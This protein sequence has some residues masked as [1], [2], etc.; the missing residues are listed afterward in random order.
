MIKLKNYTT[1][2]ELLTNELLVTYINNFWND[3]FTD[4]KN[5][6]H[7][8]LMCKVQFTKEEMGYRTLGHLRK[9][10]FKDKELFIDYLTQRLSILNDSYVAL[11]ISNIS[12]SYIIK[13]GLSTDSNRAL[14]Q[15]LTDSLTFTHNFNNMKLPISMNPSD[16]GEIVVDNYVQSGGENL[17]RFIVN[18]GSRTY[19]IDISSDSLINK[20]RILGKI[21]LEWID[22]KIN[23]IES[24]VFK[25]EIKNST[26]YFMDSQVILRKQMLPAKAFKKTSVDNKLNNYFYTLDIETIKNNGKLIPY[27]ICAYN[28]FDYITSYGKDQQELFKTFFDQLLSKIQTRTTTYIYAH[29]LAGF[30]GI[31]LMKYLLE[32]GKVEPLLHNGKLI[33]IKLKIKIMSTENSKSE[34]KTIIFK[35]SFLLLPL[36]LRKLCLAFNIETSKGY[37]PFLLNNIYYSGVIPKFENWTGISLTQFEKIVSDYKGK[38]WS[39]QLEAIKYCKLDC[40]SLHEVLIKFNILIFNEFK[41]NIHKPLTLPALAMRIYKSHYM[42]KDTIYQLL[43]RPGFNI[44]NSYTGGAVDVYI[45]HNRIGSL[46]CNIKGFF[47]K[48]YYYDVNSL[49]PFVM[50]FNDMP[51]G[52]PIAFEGNI[53]QIEPD[54]YGFFYC[55]ITSPKFLF[56]PLLQRRI[57]TQDGIRTIAGLGTWEDWINSAE[58]DNAIK[59]GYTFEILN[60]YQFKTGNIFEDYITK[61]Y[62]LRLE[63]EKGHPMNLI[64]KLL[65]NSLYG[66]FGMSLDTTEIAIYNLDKEEDRESMKN[67]LDL[68]GETYQD[69]IKIDNHLLTIRNTFLS[70]KYNEKEDMNHGQDINVAIAAAITAGA[71]VHMSYFKN[72]PLFNL[73]Y[74]DTDSAVTDKELPIFSNSNT[75]YLFGVIGIIP[76]CAGIVFYFYFTC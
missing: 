10:N 14:L 61:M 31:F 32:Y 60:G 75:S 9:V 49:Y 65:M 26:V 67:H 18:S 2:N 4:I 30:D 74:S 20:V 17:H 68:Y 46:L 69:Y 23:G 8:M 13:E 3:I 33:S 47:I 50:A 57:K 62:N 15:D 44:R 64:A 25:R 37:F 38:M 48:L 1:N 52:K 40:K 12:F 42:L 29:N 72:N 76:S 55:K 7:L 73:Y 5:T 53:R 36:S 16:Y 39:F 34:E 6:S 21:D 24:D 70:L 66:K 58:M 19:Q 28:G 22:T 45:P 56:H 27:L 41:V 35:D 54:A 51:I 71:R 11:P 43:G 59:F 63:Y